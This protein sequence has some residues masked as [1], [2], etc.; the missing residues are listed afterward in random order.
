ML[1]PKRPSS[2]AYNFIFARNILQL[3]YFYYSLSFLVL[4]CVCLSNFF[5]LSCVS[6]VLHKRLFLWIKTEQHFRLSR[7]WL[8]RMASSGTRHRVAPVRADVPLKL[9]CL[10][11]PTIALSQKTV[12]FEYKSSDLQLNAKL[13]LPLIKHHATPLYPQKLALNFVDMW[14]SLSWYSSLAD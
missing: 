6:L 1:R 13:S 4:V 8:S 2:C 3:C 10:K 5:F 12:F 11:E 7:L 14:R 9:H